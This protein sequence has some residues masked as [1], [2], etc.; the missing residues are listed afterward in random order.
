MKLHLQRAAFAAAL[1]AGAGAQAQS[2][3]TVF[4]AVDLNLTYSKAGKGSAVSL[5][6]GGYMLPSRF[7]F[8]AGQDLGGGLSTSVWLEAAV[9]PDT[10]QTSGAFSRRSTVSLADKE[11]GEVRLG[12]DY[13]PT[14]WNVSTFSPFGTVGVGGSSNIIEGW[15][16]GLGGARTQQRASN[17]VGY[18]LPAGLGGFYGQLMRA[19]SE[20]VAG[21]AYTGGR[22][23]YE[24]GPLN[25]AVAYGRTAVSDADYVSA[26]IGG[27][28]D[29]GVAKLHGNYLQHRLARDRQRAV[30][31]GVSVPFAGGTVKASA[32]RSTRSQ[33]GATTGAA[34]QFALGYT[35]AL[36]RRTT[37]Y[38]TVSRIANHGDAA[39]VTSDATSS[40]AA[41]GMPASGVQL[42]IV[43][44]F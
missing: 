2:S 42:G 3:V 8:K 32:A 27:S 28:Y 18:F 25:V 43:H 10:G 21:N 5:D 34:N 12:R 39:Y 37:V 22:F 26:N 16:L 23:G 7:G 41:A 30:L 4:G 29:F 44:A 1:C 20:G 31:L 17:A 33:D 15:P 38:G 14:F 19:M 36:S 11:W 6:Q 9:L 24:S 35:Y 40:A 13:T